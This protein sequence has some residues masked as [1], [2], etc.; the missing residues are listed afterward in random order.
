MFLTC[1]LLEELK[2]K[3]AE[4]LKQRLVLEQ[5]EEEGNIREAARRKA[6]MRVDLD[7]YNITKRQLQVFLF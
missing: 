6:N 5:Q 3:E 2:L 7:R 1:D 4:L